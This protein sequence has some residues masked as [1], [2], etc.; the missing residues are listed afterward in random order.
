MKMKELSAM[1][2]VSK[3][4]I[5]YYANEGLIPKPIK[6]SANMGYYTEEH[7]KAIRLVK[8]LQSKRFLPLTI[9]K[10]M[11]GDSG[12]GISMDE[13]KT[14]A[15]MDGKLFKNLN[16]FMPKSLMTAVQLSKRIGIS[17]EE[18]QQLE[19]D[20]VL[21]PI[22]KGRKAYY[23]DDDIHFLECGTKLRAIGFSEELGFE[24]A[25]IKIHRKMME[26]LVHEEAKY[27]LNRL[28]GKKSAAEIVKMVEDG[29]PVLNAILGLLHKRFIIKTAAKYAAALKKNGFSK[30][31]TEE[32]N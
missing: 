28:T 9:I 6:T 2:G 15:E 18:I 16:V 5:R 8:E 11:I 31:E 30:V 32:L 14:L 24:S 17:L 22:R 19:S 1:T 13:I 10:Q 4:T 7:V 27:I 12:S 23:N 21:Q 3:G 25:V 26:K 20:G 29:V